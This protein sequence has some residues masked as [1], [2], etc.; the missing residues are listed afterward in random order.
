MEENSAEGKSLVKTG[1]GKKKTKEPV[2][3]L[4]GND[5]S[6]QAMEAYKLLRTKLQF[7]FADEKDCHVIGVCSALSGE[8]KSVSAINLAHTISQMNKRVLLIDCDMRRPSVSRKL[9]MNKTTGLSEFLSA[10]SQ[11]GSLIQMCGLKGAEEAFHVIPAGKTP[12]NPVELLSSARMKKLLAVLR[13]KYAYIILD[14]PPVGEVSDALAVA[15]QTDGMI[16]VVRQNMC[17]RNKL[18]DAVR[19]LEF[20]NTKILG[21]VFNC[22]EEKRGLY[23]YKNSGVY[24]NAYEKSAR[25]AEKKQKK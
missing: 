14:L 11:A 15:D 12:P 7:S 25:M 3:E 4:V 21:L 20:L 23:A 2:V 10:Q 22:T 19:Q 13:E 6:F 8:G 16:L 18:A 9:Q 17:D 24:G 1:K 5:I